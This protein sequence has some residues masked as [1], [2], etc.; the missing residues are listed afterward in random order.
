MLEQLLK[1][2]LADAEDSL[3]SLL[4]LTEEEKKVLDE[5]KSNV[6]IDNDAGVYAAYDVFT[7]TYIF[8][9]KAVRDNV[10][11]GEEVAH[12]IRMRLNKSARENILHPVVGK[13]GDKS[14]IS[15]YVKFLNAEEYFARYFA[16]IYANSKGQANCNNLW[17]KFENNRFSGFTATFEYVTHFLGYGRAEDDYNHKGSKGFGRPLLYDDNYE[18]I[19]DIAVYDSR[20]NYR[21]AA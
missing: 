7:N 11:V 3:A 21:A 10:A 4:D 8:S 1:M 9:E 19:P 12:S 16:L 20:S 5:N 6:V 17:S 18:K 14:D 2:H 15:D 13:N